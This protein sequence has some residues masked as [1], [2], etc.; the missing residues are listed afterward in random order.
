M[1]RRIE[2]RVANIVSNI[3]AIIVANIAANIVAIFKSVLGFSKGK[4]KL[5]SK[6]LKNWSSLLR[7]LEPKDIIITLFF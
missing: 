1:T 5:F 3:V 7:G 2:K 6:V 4:I